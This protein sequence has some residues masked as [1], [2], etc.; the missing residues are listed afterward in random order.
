MKPKIVTDCDSLGIYWMD[1]ELGDEG[2]YVVLMEGYNTELYAPDK[3]DEPIESWSGPNIGVFI[4]KMVSLNKKNRKIILKRMKFEK[5]E[6]QR[7]E[8]FFKKLPKLS[9]ND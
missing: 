8:K 5:D 6:E 7:R 1:K 3:H 4:R 2:F 9:Y